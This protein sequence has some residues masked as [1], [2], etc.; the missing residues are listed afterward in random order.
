MHAEVRSKKVLIV[1]PHSR[2][3]AKLIDRLGRNGCKLYFARDC[4][5]AKSMFRSTKMDLVLS[6][7]VLPDGTADQF[8]HSLEGCPSQVFFAN[9]L[10]DSS[11][12]LHVL[13][14]GKNHWWKPSLLSPGQFTEFLEDCF[15]SQRA[16]AVGT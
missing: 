15:F 7:L 13:I 8:L 6:Q 5:S 2:P 4:K 1:T 9:S 11:W 10:E 16:F 12:W 14:Q 3:A